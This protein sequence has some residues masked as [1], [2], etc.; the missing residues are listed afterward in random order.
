[1][2]C[3]PFGNRKYGTLRHEILE[4][5]KDGLCGDLSDPDAL[6]ATVKSLAPDVIVNAAAYTAVDQAESEPE[7]AGRINAQAPA[8]KLQAG[9]HPA[10]KRL[11]PA[12]A[13]LGG[14]SAKSTSRNV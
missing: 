12:Y 5:I 2:L 13:A 14:R 3:F 7:K 8:Q 1:L 9:H 4:H 6:T 10:A 11:R